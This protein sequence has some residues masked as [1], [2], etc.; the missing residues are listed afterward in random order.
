MNQKVFLEHKKNALYKLKKAKDDN[1]VDE[2]IVKILDL[3]NSCDDYFTSSSC[4]GRIVLLNIPV[5]GDK[6]QA[7]FLGK[8]HSTIEV[9]DIKS[10]FKSYKTGLLW[11]LAQSPI[12]HVVSKNIEN[13]DIMVKY[14][15]SCGFKNSGV[16]SLGKKIV[17][18]ICSTE[19]L[20]TPIGKDGTIF[21]NDDYLNL[22]VEICN[23]VF[24][25]SK[26]KLLRFEQHLHQIIKN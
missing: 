3:I 18:E 6:K 14:G 5:I 25:K 9:D 8:W 2:G 13:A 26:D 10:V 22:I 12:I 23:D 11:I 21:C 19:R 17:V 20:D 1:L 24:L 15:I 7:S 16:R 4:Y